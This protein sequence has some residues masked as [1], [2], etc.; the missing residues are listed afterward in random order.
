VLILIFIGSM[1][2]GYHYLVDGLGGALVAGF[3]Y[4]VAKRYAQLS[5]PPP[6]DLGFRI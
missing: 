6:R 3:G 5:A 4:F 1:L 2:T